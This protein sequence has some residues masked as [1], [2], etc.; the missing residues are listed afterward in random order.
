MGGDPKRAAY[1]AVV[2]ADAD[3]EFELRRAHESVWFF[4]QLGEWHDGCGGGGHEFEHWNL[5][6]GSDEHACGGLGLLQ[7]FGVDELCE[8]VLPRSVAVKNNCLGR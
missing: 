8:P 4:D 1:R 2:A 6:A 5:A 7:R 3:R